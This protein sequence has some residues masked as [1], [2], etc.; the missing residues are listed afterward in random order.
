MPKQA[1]LKRFELRLNNNI[2]VEMHN[3]RVVKDSQRHVIHLV[4]NPIRVTLMRDGNKKVYASSNDLG[5][6]GLVKGLPEFMIRLLS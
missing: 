6:F 1:L 2:N 4:G 3:I 5:L